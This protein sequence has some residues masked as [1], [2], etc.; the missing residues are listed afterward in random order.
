MGN[1]AQ[2]IAVCCHRFQS[3]NQGNSLSALSP[4]RLPNKTPRPTRL[5][6]VIVV[7]CR[8]ELLAGFW[9]HHTLHAIARAY[10][11]DITSEVGIGRTA[12]PGSSALHSAVFG[13]LLSRRPQTL[14]DSI[15]ANGGVPPQLWNKTTRKTTAKANEIRASVRQ[16]RL[17]GMIVVFWL[18]LVVAAATRPPH[19]V[20]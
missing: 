19:R 14:R 4:L 3:R 8:K 13:G 15:F 16:L 17:Y 12:R 9:M 10:A 7:D 1:S 18:F 20:E 2:G 5:G 6:L 11:S